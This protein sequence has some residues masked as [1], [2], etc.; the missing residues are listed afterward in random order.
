MLTA[1][2]NIQKSEM[3][4]KTANLK[5]FSPTPDLPSSFSA[6]APDPWMSAGMSGRR[7]TKGRTSWE[8]SAMGGHTSFVAMIS[9]ENDRK[10]IF[11]NRWGTSFYEATQ[12]GIIK[13]KRV[14]MLTQE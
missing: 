1:K 12:A 10:F 9:R 7:P 2:E 5:T 13:H 6:K 11:L 4:W 8:R 14:F 3:C